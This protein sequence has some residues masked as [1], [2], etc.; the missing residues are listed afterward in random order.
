MKLFK[1]LKGYNNEEMEGA[2]IGFGIIKSKDY[3]KDKLGHLILF[4]LNI[5]N[6]QLIRK[7]WV[8]F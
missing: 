5:K 8:W 3:E 1:K 2:L 4:S 6:L 7:L